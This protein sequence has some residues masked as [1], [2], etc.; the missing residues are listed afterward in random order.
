MRAAACSTARSSS[1]SRKRS[2]PWS[3]TSAGTR[4]SS[5]SPRTRRWSRLP[6]RRATNRI[7]RTLRSPRT[8]ARAPRS[9][10]LAHGGAVMCL[11]GRGPLDEAIHDAGAAPAQASPGHAGRSPSRRVPLGHHGPRRLVRTD[12]VHLVPRDQ[13]HAGPALSPAPPAPANPHRRSSSAS[14]LPTRR[15][16]RTRSCAPWWEPIITSPRSGRP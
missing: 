12:G 15:S 3:A 11:A 6:L 14:G 5:P 1:A 13:R 16:S 10:G 8:A 2:K 4:T 7:S 9:R